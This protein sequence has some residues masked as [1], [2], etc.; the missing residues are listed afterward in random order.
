MLRALAQQTFVATLGILIVALTVDLA[1]QLRQ[2]LADGPE[3]EGLWV[4]VRLARY[5]MLRSMDF[6]PRLL[7][8]GCFLGVMACEFAHTW[9]RERLAVWNSGRSP[10][11]CL[12]PA[13]MLSLLA[14]FIQIGL[15]TYLR[16][17]AVAAQVAEGLGE[18]GQ[19]FDRRPT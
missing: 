10:L 5:L 18:Y 8:I 17:A 11:Q 1:P 15:D 7:P 6:G 16:P 12:L 9:S 2:V 14:G 19:R 4:V 3:G 13:I